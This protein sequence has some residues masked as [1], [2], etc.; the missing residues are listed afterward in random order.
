MTLNFANYGTGINGKE[1]QETL[2]NGKEREKTQPA[3]APNPKTR[4]QSGTQRTKILGQK[5]QTTAQANMH[6]CYKKK[7][8]G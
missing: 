2:R 7:L 1:R 4:K 5:E 3:N 8:D 6:K